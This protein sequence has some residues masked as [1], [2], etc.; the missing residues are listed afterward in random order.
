MNALYIIGGM[1]S[2]AMW[3]GLIY[4]MIVQPMRL[5]H[6]RREVRL[7]EQVRLTEPVRLTE[8]VPVTKHLSYR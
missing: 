2:A 8:Q 4:V 6:H 1:L 3:L 7:I 5:H